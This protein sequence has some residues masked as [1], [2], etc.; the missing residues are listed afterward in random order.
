[1]GRTAFR[2]AMTGL[3]SLCAA[4]AGAPAPETF[5][6]GSPGTARPLRPFARQLLVSEPSAL[7][8]LDGDQLV[9]IGNGRV[10]MIGG[11]Q[12]S[13]RIPRLVQSRIVQGFEE[14]GRSVGRVGSG[15]ASE[16]ILGLDLRAFQLNSAAEAPIVEVEIAARMSDGASGQIIAARTFRATESVESASPAQVS[17]GLARA[18]DEVTKTLVAWAIANA[19]RAP[20]SMPTLGATG[21]V[22]R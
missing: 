22:Q 14:Q 3:V 6:L 15:L 18:L 13:D 7:L 20:A 17:A 9:V 2:L 1:M 12:W 5:S 4:C 11:G 16:R 21:S 19:A 8:P 10:S